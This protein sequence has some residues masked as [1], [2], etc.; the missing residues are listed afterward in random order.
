LIDIG[1]ILFDIHQLITAPSWENAGWLAADVVLGITPYVPAG[2]GPAAKAAKAAQAANKVADATKSVDIVRATSKADEAGQAFAKAARLAGD[3][4]AAKQ[5][6]KEAGKEDK[7]IV[8]G[9]TMNPR[10]KAIAEKLGAKTFPGDR[11]LKGTALL[12]KNLEW[13]QKMIDEGY[14]IVDIGADSSRGPLKPGEIDF[15][16]WE[17]AL[18]KERGY[19]WVIRLDDIGP[20]SGDRYWHTPY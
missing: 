20:P 6:I 16:A 10:V 15:Y 13:L 2:A 18:V 14:V 11:A 7:V 12:E 8:I 9:R 5:L 19:N 1:S 4:D 17:A 3:I